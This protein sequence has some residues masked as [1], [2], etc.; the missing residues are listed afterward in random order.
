MKGK[1][2]L[3][4]MELDRIELLLF[5]IFRDSSFPLLKGLAASFLIGGAG[6]DDLN[7]FPLKRF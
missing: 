4:Y 2:L 5:L 1:D 6:K 7:A 3:C